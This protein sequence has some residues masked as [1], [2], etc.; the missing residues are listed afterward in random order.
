M[1]SR[2]S[3]LFRIS[4][5]PAVLSTALFVAATLTSAANAQ[6]VFSLGGKEYA[7]KDLGVSHQ[8]AWFDVEN[9]RFEKSKRIVDD[10]V[11]DMYVEAEAKK[12]GK[13]KETFEEDFAKVKE[14]TDKDAKVWFDKNKDRVPYPYE[15]I[16]GEIKK[17]LA[18]ELIQEKRAKALEDYKKKN[19]FAFTM[20]GPVAPVV[21]IA[22]AGFP[23]RG[24]DNARVTIVEF[25]DYQCPHCK[26]AAT[27]M[28]GVVAKMKDKVRL[29]YLDFPINP[30]GISL[31][32]AHGAVCADEQKKFWE[33]H[34]LAFDKQSTLTKDSPAALAKELKLDEAAFSTCMG[35]ARPAERVAKAK[36]EG[37]RLGV[38]GTPAIYING[39]RMTHAPTEEEI[40]KHV[41]EALKGTAS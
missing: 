14:A 4:S 1:R 5:C 34:H 24:P 22:T 33:Y 26:A 15:Q 31:T 28:K 32:V 18:S 9:E 23:S 21:Q 8:Q 37:E 38:Q 2:S 29:I 3:Q 30:S 36:A 39:V 13:S 41:N 40:T 7:V 10:I 25:A 12:A 16:K 6:S 35:S 20:T 19:K 11:F 27:A 17:L